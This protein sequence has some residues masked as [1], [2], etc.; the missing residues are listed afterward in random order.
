MVTVLLVLFSYLLEVTIKYYLPNTGIYNYLEP[1]FLVSFLIVYII[2]NHKKKKSLSM[3]IISTLI[4]DFFFGNIL[5]LYTLIFLILYYFI[6]FISKHLEQYFLIR[7][8]IFIMSFI[9]FFILK[10][11]ILLW[12]GYNYSII[13][14]LNQIIHSIIIN[15][16]FGLTIYYVL[17]IK[18][19]KA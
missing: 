7:T 18:L 16:L 3:V 8:F 11:I 6:R 9:L 13:F 10:Y 15:I 1:M 14:L 12:I 2:I 5:F 17:G 4:Y 19:K